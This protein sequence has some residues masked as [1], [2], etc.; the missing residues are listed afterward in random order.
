MTPPS[1]LIAAH[2]R[3]ILRPEGSSASDPPHPEMQ[4][5]QTGR[6]VSVGPDVSHYRVGDLVAYG[7]Y[8]GNC[9]HEQVILRPEEIA[10][11]V[12]EDAQWEDPLMLSSQLV[13]LV[14]AVRDLCADRVHACKYVRPEDA[15]P[16]LMSLD[17]ATLLER[18][19]KRLAQPTV[20]IGGT[21]LK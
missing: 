5:L 4:P 1:K 13:Q 6:V 18:A 15:R 3:L 20:T 10:A 9:L 7:H 11:R 16:D 8:A 19:L 21:E 17:S 14:G 2:G 12:E